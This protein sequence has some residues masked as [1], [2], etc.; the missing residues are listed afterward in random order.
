M[1]EIYACARSSDH[2]DE[3]TRPLRFRLMLGKMQE[4]SEARERRNACRRSAESRTCHTR[5]RPDGDGA[6][7]WRLGP[8]QPGLCDEGR[9][10]PAYLGLSCGNSGPASPATINEKHQETAEAETTAQGAQ[11]IP[12][13]CA[14]PP[15]C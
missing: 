4:H 13:L 1:D 11:G 5:E 7:S 14:F 8:E 2:V 9:P 3:S 15:S 12:S 10:E 6:Q